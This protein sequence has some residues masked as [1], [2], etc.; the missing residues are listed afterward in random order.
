MNIYL[1]L[2]LSISSTGYCIIND[3]FKIISYGKIQT[4]KDHFKTE[5]KRI[6]HICN[7][8]DSLIKK[9]NVTIGVFEDQYLG[10]NPKTGLILRKCL[11]AAIKTFDNHNIEC[12]YMKP[13]EVRKVLFNQGGAKKDRVANYIRKYYL[14]I[15]ELNDRNCKDK[16]SDI[17]DAVALGISYIKSIKE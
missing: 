7:E 5:D 4:K 14:D 16:N 3:N 6:F 8:I 13:T 1:A 17:Y 9:H 11:G 12:F 2:D 10:R 15:G